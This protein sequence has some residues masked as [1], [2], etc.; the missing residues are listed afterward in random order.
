MQQDYL[1]RMIQQFG[2]FVAA[3]LNLHKNG[4]SLEALEQLTEGYGRFSGL[5]PTLVHA[6]GEEDLVQL[7]HSRGGIDPQR[8]WSLAELLREEA[9]IYDDL[10][11]PAESAPRF[12]KS[13]RL[14]LEVIDEIEDLTM[15]LNVTGLEEIISRIDEFNLPRGTRERTIE[16]LERSGRLDIAENIVAWSLEIE[17]EDGS[18]HEDADAFYQR[19]LARPDGDLI[20]A[21][22]TRQEVIESRAQFTTGEDNA[23]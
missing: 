6:L 12:I 9:I 3:V 14:Y 13:L 11:Q 19:L 2:G 10:G 20:A 4:K 17:D 5:N 1:L 23:E 21:G 15:P 22:M 18:R 8:C 16:Y 7:L